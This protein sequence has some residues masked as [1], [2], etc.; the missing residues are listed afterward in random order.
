MVKRSKSLTAA[1]SQFAHKPVKKGITYGNNLADYSD[2]VACW[3]LAHMALQLR[4]GLL[5]ERRDRVGLTNL[6][7]IVGF[8]TDITICGREARQVKGAMR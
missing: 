6:G 1:R 8:G 5:P 4:L 2:F 3:C 7:Y